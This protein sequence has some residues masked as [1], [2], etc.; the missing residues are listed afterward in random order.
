MR[1]KLTLDSENLKYFDAF[2]AAV[3][4]RALLLA[5]FELLLGKKRLAVHE[6]VPHYSLTC[7]TVSGELD[8]SSNLF[9]PRED[10][11]NGLTL[12]AALLS[13]AEQL[14]STSL[15]DRSLT[16]DARLP[17]QV[18]HTPKLGELLEFDRATDVIRCQI[19]DWSLIVGKNFTL[20]TELAG[21]AN[22]GLLP[23][24]EIDGTPLVLPKVSASI[25]KHGKGPGHLKDSVAVVTGLHQ[26]SGEAELR[27]EG[28]REG[29]V[30]RAQLSDAARRAAIAH[31]LPFTAAVTYSEPTP[32][33]PLLPMEPSKPVIEK[34]WDFQEQGELSLA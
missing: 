11:V 9:S 1:F 28:H 20:L 34:M 3:Q 10:L 27:V 15:T 13:S 7:V 14:L 24:V 5:L 17:I 23:T 22:A 19:P 18:V 29:R 32:R 33:L 6:L 31:R 30:V 21:I 4:A 12:A 25:L 26:V 8:S 2:L 16:K